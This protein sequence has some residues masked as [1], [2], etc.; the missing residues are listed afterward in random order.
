M[1]GP[2]APVARP[3]AHSS[4]VYLESRLDG[5][6]RQPAGSRGRLAGDGLASEGAL[7]RAEERD[8]HDAQCG[9]I[10]AGETVGRWESA[11]VRPVDPFERACRDVS[12]CGRRNEPNHM[13]SDALVQGQETICPHGFPTACA[14]RFALLAH[15][16]LS[17]PCI[18]SAHAHTYSRGE[19][20]WRRGGPG[21][22]DPLSPSSQTWPRPPRH[23][24]R[25]PVQ[26]LGGCR[27]ATA[28]GTPP[29]PTCPRRGGP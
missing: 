8:L 18:S 5:L 10:C 7:H 19:T 22:Q 24:P 28:P 15:A 23:P 21:A 16:S 27:A 14:W 12:R 1:Q 13:C 4:E 11:V 9:L 25:P 26:A 29:R 20:S 2:C 6:A 3:T 17:Q